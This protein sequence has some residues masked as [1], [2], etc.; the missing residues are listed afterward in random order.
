MYQLEKNHVT[1]TIIRHSRK[2]MFFS[3]YFPHLQ[4]FMCR[5]FVTGKLGENW[6]T[7][8]LGLVEPLVGLLDL[9]HHFVDAENLKI[10]KN[11][12]KVFRGS[13]FP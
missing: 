4:L 7:I 9:G 8:V 1:T 6:H 11:I 2:A 12:G 5:S 13:I 10:G 3:H